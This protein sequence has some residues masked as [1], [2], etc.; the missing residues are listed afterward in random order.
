MP[1]KS[2]LACSLN[3]PVAYSAA[4]ARLHWWASNALLVFLEFKH[5]DQGF[6]TSQPRVE[7]TIWVLAN[8]N[9]EGKE[10]EP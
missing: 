2:E 3:A 4:K 5:I 1:Q 10:E 7:R 8:L 6:S 9:K